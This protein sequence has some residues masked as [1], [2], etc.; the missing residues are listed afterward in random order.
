MAR[1]VASPRIAVP[2]PEDD[3]PP[4]ARVGI[5][6]AVG[7]AIGVVWPW[8]AGVRFVPQAPGGGDDRTPAAVEPAA[9]A[10]APPT[11]ATPPEP[12]APAPQRTTEQQVK[13]GEAIIVSCRDERGNKKKE[14]DRIDFDSVARDKLLAL[15]ACPAAKGAA[16]ILSIG[17]DIDLE[18]NQILKVEKGKSTTFDDDKA[19]ALLAC[20]EREFAAVDLS[21]IPHEHARYSVFYLAEFVP[22]GTLLKA[23][24]ASADEQ[25][26][27]ASGL[28]TVRWDVA[29]VRDEPDTG[30]VRARLRY[31]TRVKVAARRGKWYLIEYDAK[32]SK[33]WV[34]Q[35]AIGL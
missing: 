4:L 2:R 22:P 30:D 34:H 24:G 13:V 25:T 27:E 8:L 5:I 33:G 28:A 23:E 3:R 35:N 6:A 14:C 16:K 9:S 10:P 11:P 19:K 7:F 15:A 20:A 17:F 12:P 31:G 1:R 29:L 21:K 26:V 18:K 32:G